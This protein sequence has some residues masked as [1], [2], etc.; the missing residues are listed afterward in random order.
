MRHQ[1][2]TTGAMVVWLILTTYETQASK[3]CQTRQEARQ[4]WPKAY[5]YW[6]GGPNGQRCWSDRRG[7]RQAHR[8]ELAVP[9]E[10]PAAAPGLI[11]IPHGLVPPLWAEVQPR[12]I[13]DTPQWAWV[14]DA[15]AYAGD[16]RPFT[17]FEG[18]EPDVWPIVEPAVA[19]SA[20]L[21]AV[22]LCGMAAFICGLLGWRWNRERIRWRG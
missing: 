11:V 5:L 18:R 1:L 12:S 17:T 16:E 7:R 4:T 19:G 3:A 10:Q 2:A 13:L 22:L 21:V 14:A 8:K 9:V 6:S 15:R 20:S